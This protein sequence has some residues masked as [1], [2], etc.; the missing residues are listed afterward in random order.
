M[1]LLYHELIVG[2]A[3]ILSAD[4]I[5]EDGP[6]PALFTLKKWNAVAMWSWDVQC[7]KW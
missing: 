1:E 6:K 4:Q 2:Y 3:F 7:D 5:M